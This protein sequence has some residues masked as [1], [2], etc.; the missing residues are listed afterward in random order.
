M[1]TRTKN[2]IVL[3]K[4][5]CGGFLFKIFEPKMSI[6]STNVA[7]AGNVFGLGEVCEA[8]GCAVGQ[9]APNPCYVSV[10]FLN[11]LCD[12]NRTI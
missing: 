1:A 4:Q 12:G 8:L 6:R 10:I 9:I 3:K 5:K 7:L 11:F 2:Q